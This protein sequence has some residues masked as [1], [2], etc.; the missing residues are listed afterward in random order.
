MQTLALTARETI[1]IHTIDAPTPRP[2][3]ILIRN[4]ACGVCGGDIKTFKRSEE[5]TRN[6][7]HVIGGHEHVGQVIAVGAEVSG[8]TVGDRVAHVFNNYCG[9]C[10][11][12]RL[13][14]PNFCLNFRRAG[15]GGFA[16]EATLYA[17][18][19]GRGVFKVPESI[20][21]AEAAL[22]EPLTC[23]IG[24]VLK[25][26][27]Q[28]GERI[29][30][31]GLGG[32]GQ[33]VAQILA[34]AKVAVIGIDQQPDKLRN[35][36]QFCHAVID[37]SNQDVLAETLRLTGNAGADAVIEV[38]GIPETFKQAIEL[39]RMGGRVTIGGSHTRLAD[40]VNIDRI[41]RKELTIKTSK[42]AA[43]LTGAD[44]VPL[45]FR[46]I[47]EGIAR[48]QELLTEFPFAQAQHAFMGQAHGG[49]IKAVIMHEFT[50]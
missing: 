24:I 2:D 25:T 50:K 13:G 34:A 21:T 22:C 26:V 18:N 6:G 41:F 45:A 35:A 28:P 12:C 38:V 1:A 8:F 40:G 9:A 17:G 32:L 31:I 46:Y 49:I 42:G 33:F 11:N 27:P 43:P 37:F 16:D 23:A 5:L 36:A 48:P 47:E 10:L 44:G 39:A 4:L 29:V 30:V 19:F 15:G 7:P 20:S 3:E 14:Q